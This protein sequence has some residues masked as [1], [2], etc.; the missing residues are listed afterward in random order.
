MASEEQVNNMG[1]EIVDSKVFVP[2]HIFCPSEDYVFDIVG[3][4]AGTAYASSTDHDKCVQRV[5]RCIQQGH[6]SPLEHIDITLQVLTDRGTSHALVRHRH[7]AFTQSSTIYTKVKD[8]LA[9][10]ALPAFDPLTGEKVVPITDTELNLYQ[11]DVDEY[12]AL[13]AEGA[14]ASRARDVLPTCTATTLFMTT[15]LRE[16]YFIMHRRNGKGDAVRMHVF[17]NLLRG[18]FKERFP[19]ITEYMDA[20]YEEHP[21]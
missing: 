21:L 2:E 8:S 14:P 6:H 15:N 12:N 5:I 4:A 19:S 20:W 7:C 3:R 18:F 13:I 1:I 16:W 11:A 9:I 10:V 17:D